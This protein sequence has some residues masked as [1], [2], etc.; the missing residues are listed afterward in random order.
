MRTPTEIVEGLVALGWTQRQI[1]DATGTSQPTIH[2]ILHGAS[3]THKYQLVDSLRKL[4]H[5]LMD[6]GE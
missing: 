2:R 5:E 3:V 6:L 4:E 1:A